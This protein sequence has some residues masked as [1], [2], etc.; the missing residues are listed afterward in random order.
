MTMKDF[1]WLGKPQQ[2]EK[3]YKE[4]SLTVEGNLCL[5]EGPLVLAVSDEDFTLKLTTTVAPEGGLCGVCLYHT[6]ES[7]TSVGRSTTNLHIESSVRSYK[8]TTQVPLP[9]SDKTVQW[10]IERK[11]SQV[12][13]GYALPTGKEIAWVSNT[14][15]PGM[16][17]SVS[18]GVFF[19][20][21]T[22]TPFE[23]GM[24]SL[25]YSKSELLEP[26]PLV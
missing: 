4:L 11:G 18:F 23:A 21:Y 24:H 9:T 15:I 8:T 10:H 7:Y 1:R 3:T 20:N 13:I 2:W 26:H 19:S 25:R 22:N 12:S 17:G 6:E 16:E 14:T 5:P